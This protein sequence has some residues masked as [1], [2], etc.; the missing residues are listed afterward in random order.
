[1]PFR[2]ARFS[3]CWSLPATITKAQRISYGGFVSVPFSSSNSGVASGSG[4][5]RRRTPW[6]PHTDLATRSRSGG[7]RTLEG[8]R[9]RLPQHFDEFTVS[10]HP[11][12]GARKRRTVHGSTKAESLDE[13][14]A[15]FV[16]SVDEMFGDTALAAAGGEYRANLPSG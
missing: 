9:R 10:R 7:R 4:S 12:H 13:D 6:P 11:R 8:W 15:H 2:R 5:T 3:R 14:D 1:M 16:R